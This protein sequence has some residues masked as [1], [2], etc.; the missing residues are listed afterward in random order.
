MAKD[1]KC[2]VSDL[3]NNVDLRKQ[4]HLQNY[5]SDKVG[6]PTLQ[7]ILKEL[8]K[9]GRDPRP[10]RQTF[11]F[12]NISTIEELSSGM[13]LPAVVTNITAFGAFVDIGIKENGLI[14]KSKMSNKFVDDPATIVKLGQELEVTVLDVDI[15]R[16][17]VQLS[18]VE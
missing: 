17:R 1:L 16:K 9:P 4:I 3:I 15:Q 10:A 5:T 8:E 13:K 12:A 6:L 7:D 11:S 2:K 14:H 18:L